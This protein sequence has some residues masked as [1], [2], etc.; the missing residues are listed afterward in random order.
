MEKITSVLHQGYRGMAMLMA[1][2]SLVLFSSFDLTTNS[3]TFNSGL[4]ADNF[5]ELANLDLVS[6]VYADTIYRVID[7]DRSPFTGQ[8]PVSNFWWP[9][10]ETDFFNPN[11]Y[12]S[13]QEGNEL[14]FT[15]FEDGSA[16]LTGTTTNGSC[17][18]EL[19]IWFIDRTSWADWQ[20]AGGEHKK[21]GTAGNASNS[22][23]MVFYVIDNT[24]STVTAS[25][26]GCLGTGVFSVEQRPDP[27]DSN[28]P[29]FGAHVGPGGANY[30]SRI[31]AM[32]LSTW[33]WIFDP[34]CD[35]RWVMDLN[36]LID[37]AT[38]PGIDAVDDD[39]TQV[40]I[41]GETGGT[42]PDTNVL[43]NDTLNGQ[44]VNPED[45]ILISETTGGV[46]INPDG[47]V[48]VA[49]GTPNGE[50]IIEY[51]I[52]EVA[53]P[54]NCDTASTTIQV[55]PPTDGINAVDDDFSQVFIDGETGGTLPDT[56][57]L[58]NDTLDGQP[59][60]PQ[61]IVLTSE[62]T[63][64]V[65]INPDGTITVAPGTPD[66]EVLIEYTICEVADPD[67]C[68][69][70][71]TTIFV[72][73]GGGLQIDAV[74]DDFSQVFIDG[75]TGGILPNSN[76]LD[77]DTINGQPVDSEDVV[78]SSTPSG[79]V[80]INS[81]GT[82]SVAPGT[83]DGQVILMYTICAVSNPDFCDTA[84]VTVVVGSGGGDVTIDAVDDVFVVASGTSGVQ[85]GINVLT[86]DTLDGESVN[87]E[88][89]VLSSTS[90]GGVTINP[91]GSITIA[92]GTPDGEIVLSYTICEVAN[93]SNCN[94]ASVTITIGP[95]PVIDAV[96][97]DYEVPSGSSGEIS[98]INVLDNDT[99]NG[100]PLD[101]SD[102][103][104][105][106][107]VSTNITINPDGTIT[108]ADGT[109]DG[110]IVVTYTICQIANPTNC[111]TAEVV[112]TIGIPPVIDAVDDA[113]SVNTGSSGVVPNV[114]VLTNDTLN[115]ETVDVEDVVLTSESTGGVT[116]NPDGTI[117]IAEGT[118]D[119]QIEIEYTIC[120]IAFPDNC[121]TATVIITIGPLPD[122]DAVDDIFTVDTGSNGE[123]PDINV[124]DNDILDG[125]P[126]DPADIILTSEST[127][128]VTINPDG[129]ITIA[130]GTPDGEVT[131][132]YTICEVANPT[133]CD[134]AT[135]TITIG[136]EPV[137]V[138]DA[139]D[140][141]FSDNTVDGQI[142]GI[143][144]ISNV[145][146]NDTLDSI[147]VN[148]SDVTISSDPSGPLTVNPD[149][150][151][152]VA[153][154]TPTGTYTISY[155]I[156]E[157]ANPENCDTAIVTVRVVGPIEVNQMVTPNGDGRN[158]FL[159]IRNVDRTL[160]NTLR[161]YN[162]W[163]VAVYTG[164]DYNNQ[165]NVFDGRSRG[166]S[167]LSVNDYLP[168]GVYYYIF[169]YQTT[170]EKVT[171]S[172]YI[173]ISK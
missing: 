46:T 171:D 162:R 67:N 41:D 167:T 11:A 34:T 164:S 134:T 16:H 104:L 166:R 84:S 143:V 155:T 27:D 157:N 3:E 131:I 93:P 138:I 101:P 96:D 33:G 86:N 88:D 139:V 122:I 31:G 74:D 51:T 117:T 37:D 160:T 10:T 72:G 81:D 75:E 77:N 30:D 154:D 40:F 78:L 44:P 15:Q 148:P 70:A 17:L 38:T 100:E 26:N 159:F 145:L 130:E 135:L 83:A 133:N 55:G 87:A 13:Q 32:G 128:G 18:V 121:D 82:I 65:T 79:G 111:D 156:C 169:D 107:E 52:C 92:E 173:F 21:E 161:I 94:T 23:D 8:Q 36:F 114:N 115:G 158:D 71:T 142:G 54:D 91:D 39:F 58:D 144:P 9:E 63:A 112:I 141:D 90:I 2:F 19:N 85:T 28:T 172:G 103:T 57:V 1:L 50:V 20:A 47:T 29:N 120:Q 170:Q 62:T 42:L 163:G 106:F 66:G 89:I 59:V 146:D 125:E 147:F 25:G 127:D 102:I 124:L 69:T 45:V 24:R 119:G 80:T 53:D 116:I 110:V 150:T 140:D 113:F 56:N 165:N 109:P 105:T 118:P 95:I 4:M 99:L 123:Q 22:E 152:S 60:D 5:G 149:G 48:T 153:P 132:E 35:D 136:G 129:T 98:G 7:A 43:D 64:G 14:Q 6:P 76:V 108:I 126:V 137:L 73:D 151:V 61:D 68:D 168:S 49:P 97:D 12:F